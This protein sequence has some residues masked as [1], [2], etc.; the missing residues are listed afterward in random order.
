MLWELYAINCFETYRKDINLYSLWQARIANPS[1]TLWHACITDDRLLEPYAIINVSLITCFFGLQYAFCSK[2]AAVNVIQ[3]IA[4]SLA[5]NGEFVCII[6]DPE[7]ILAAANGKTYYVVGNP[8]YYGDSYVFRYNG[9]KWEEWLVDIEFLTNECAKRKL[10][11]MQ[12]SKLTDFAEEYQ[13]DQPEM[14]LT[15]SY[16]ICLKFVKDT[17]SDI[18]PATTEENFHHCVTV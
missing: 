4:S 11:L 15:S 1:V 8:T 12:T 18:I 5:P 17:G 14:N 10:H 9:S 2:A 6:P 16:Y 3:F 13:K 7:Q